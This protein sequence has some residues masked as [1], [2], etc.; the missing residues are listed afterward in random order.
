MSHLL[1][2]ADQTREAVGH[3]EPFEVFQREAVGHQEPLEV[4]QSDEL[5]SCDSINSKRVPVVAPGV[6]GALV[7]PGLSGA[8]PMTSASCSRTFSANLQ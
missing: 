3:Q 8:L 7:A 5:N 4:S 6:S 2:Y 1:G